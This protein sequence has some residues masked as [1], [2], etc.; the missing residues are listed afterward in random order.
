MGIV[1]SFIIFNII[2]FTHG[3]SNS[4]YKV[5]ISSFTDL[6]LDLN[7]DYFLK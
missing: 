4:G 3:S 1:C 5:L 6:E 2:F 7:K